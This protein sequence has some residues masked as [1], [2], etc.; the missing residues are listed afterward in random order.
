MRD[1]QNIPSSNNLPFPI[2]PFL[3][4]GRNP[5]FE[6]IMTENSV[7]WVKSPMNML[8]LSFVAED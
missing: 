6:Y 4:S 7:V 5:Y 1:S 2:K 8:T 3:Q